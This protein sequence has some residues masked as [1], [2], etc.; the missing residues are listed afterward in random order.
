MY[1][2]IIKE[3][4]KIINDHKENGR[5]I[6][7]IVQHGMFP[8]EL[9][10]AAGAIPLHFI[11]G[12]KDEQEIGDSYLSSTTCPFGRATLGFLEKKNKLYSLLDTVIVGTFCNGV[13]NVANYLLS[14]QKISQRQILPR[15]LERF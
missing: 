15:R 13:Q 3:S 11:L 6:V 1:S 10:V 12:G 9:V 5:K 4:T 7:G 14:L 8:D 2:E